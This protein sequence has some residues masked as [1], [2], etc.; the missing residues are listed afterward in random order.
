MN[1]ELSLC[2]LS[3]FSCSFFSVN[4]YTFGCCCCFGLLE[5][6]RTFHSF[7]SSSS[8]IESL[9]RATKNKIQNKKKTGKILFNT[10]STI[11]LLIG[12][13]NHGCGGCRKGRGSRGSWEG[14]RKYKKKKEKETSKWKKKREFEEI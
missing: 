1:S 4:T 12:P 14:M 11:T 10:S 9:S 6:L 3:H 8:F 7:N 5:M 2:F 13:I